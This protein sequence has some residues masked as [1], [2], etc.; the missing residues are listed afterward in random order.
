MK[1]RYFTLALAISVLGLAALTAEAAPPPVEFNPNASPILQ[2][3]WTRLGDRYGE[4]G[5]VESAEFSPDGTLIVS[6]GK[7][8]NSLVVWRVDDGTV[9]WRRELDDEIERAGFSRDG[10]Y[11]VSTGEDESLR[12]W[13]TSDGTPVRTIP[14]DTAVDGMA[15]SP[16]GKTLVTGKEGG[17]VQAWSF[18]E[19]KLQRSIDV[20]GTVNSVTFTRD[21]RYVALGG[22]PNHVHLLNAA[23]FSIVHKLEGIPDL[24]VISVRIADDKELLAAGQY[25]GYISVW[26]LE[27]GKLVSRFNHTGRK[28]EAITWTNDGN[29]LLA[30]G[31]DEYIRVVRTADIVMSNI[32]IAHVSPRAGRSEYLEFSPNGATM[33]SAHEDGTIRLWLWKS[34]DEDINTNVCCIWCA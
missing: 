24:A 6:G 27:E 23:D 10:R 7:Y 9:L 8:D 2:P 29:Y 14:L 15:F 19:M 17:I 18:P 34:G 22:H 11:V 21:G 31:H 20:G 16:D 28:V 12:L 4:I 5:A 25:G 13:N 3:I 30:A 1:S 33:V 32:P 26:S